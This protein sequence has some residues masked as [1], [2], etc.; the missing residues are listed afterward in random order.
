[1]VSDLR[2]G[3]G[4]ADIRFY[5]LHRAGPPSRPRI[6]PQQHG[7][8]RLK[9]PAPGNGRRRSPGPSRRGW[10]ELPAG[11]TRRDG[12]KPLPHPTPVVTAGTVTR[13]AGVLN[14]A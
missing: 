2:R 4:M 14:Q 10:W 7:P 1:M 6:E 11:P 12:P 9:N 8:E 3:E 13:R 5:L